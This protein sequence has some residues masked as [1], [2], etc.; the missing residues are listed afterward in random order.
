ML[1]VAGNAALSDLI[2]HVDQL[3]LPEVA[4]RINRG[5]GANG[6][7]L[8]GGSA[9]TVALAARN[10]GAPVALWHRL[11]DTAADGVDLSALRRAGVDLSRCSVTADQPGRCLIV[12]V[13]DERLCWST[14]AADDLFVSPELLTD[15]THV[16][17]CPQWGVWSSDLARLASER[18]IPCSLVGEVPPEAT[19][20]AWHTVIGDWRQLEQAAPLRA[21]VV[22]ATRGG[23]GVDLRDENGSTHLPARRVVPVDPTGVGDVF[24]GTM[25]SYMEQGIPTVEAA[26][27]A[28]ERARDTCLRWGAM[29]AFDQ[30]A[31]SDADLPARV[32]GALWGL[33]C[34]DAFGMP[35]SFL[36]KPK[37]RSTME[38][39][40]AN[41]PYHAGYPAGRITDDTE[42][43]LALT[44]A[45]GQ[46][47]GRPD[48]VS[49]A[50]ALARWFDSVGGV[51]SLAVGP[52]TMRAMVAY[53]NGGDVSQVGLNGVTNGASMRIAPIGVLGALR[54]AFP[55]DLIEIVV[56]ACMV[57]HYTSVAISG[58]AAVA[59]AVAAGVRGAAWDEVIAAGIEGAR[60]G[61]SQG[62]WIYAPD[63]GER[64]EWAC[65]TVRGAAS[66]DGAARTLARLVG[67]GEPTTESVPAAFAAADFAGGD[68]EPAILLAANAGGDTDTVAAMAG[69]ICGSWAGEAAIP[70]AWRR[71]VGQTNDLD[72]DAWAARLFALAGQPAAVS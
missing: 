11:P 70:E 42:Q 12:G 66:L 36:Q 19:A 6:R 28:S 54:N 63:V 7:W 67:T 61:Q 1:L 25:L 62:R 4:G 56:A 47:G 38:P 37:W 32:R 65:A 13:G 35:N 71:I 48:P 69:A 9:L 39:A 17:L 30:P 26:A 44:E 8:P 20:H 57:T 51:S 2:V 68:P 52:S 33:A 24:A 43:A 5:P 16:V 40:P 23:A 21:A 41:S 14:T 15:I 10:A 72:V 49:V 3:T 34:G 27:R 50:A 29:G 53:G 46:S 45:S 55:E 59:F 64:I 60:L 18:G 31:F 58:A 22:A